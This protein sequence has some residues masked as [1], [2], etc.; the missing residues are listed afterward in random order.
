[1]QQPRPPA[2]GLVAAIREQAERLCFVSNAWGAQPRAQLA[3]ALLRASGFEG[4]RV[5]FTLG[6]AD[7]NEHAIK[8]ARLASGKPKGAVIARDRSYHGATHLA[9]AL[10]GDART[11]RQ[12]DAGCVR[13][14]PRAAAVR[15]PLPVRQHGRGACG[16]RAAAAV[17][18]GIDALGAEH[19][20]AVIMEPD[21]GTNG[22][23]APDTYW[24]A[25]RRH[26][27]QRGVWLIADEVM[28]AFG[29]CGE[30]FAWQR[31]GE[32]GRPT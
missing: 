19:V 21:A 32:A 1:V 18:D 10:S 8:I 20:A 14:A 6:G 25:L 4:G 17:A 24:P 23:V 11:Q 31:H 28:S 29:R 27:A 7:A 3:Q 9:M 15:L 12:V 26:T 2:S 16:E 22:I 30:W 13:R 5:F